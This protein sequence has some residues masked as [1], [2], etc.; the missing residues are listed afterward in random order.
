MAPESPTDLADAKLALVRE[1]LRTR[2]RWRRTVYSLPGRAIR[3]KLLETIYERLTL[4]RSALSEW[5][6]SPPGAAAGEVCQAL[7]LI[8]TPIDERDAWQIADALS[9]VLPRVLPA[10]SLAGALWV[11]RSRTPGRGAHWRDVFECDELD[12]L[13]ADYDPGARRFATEGV[14]SLV[15]E[16][17][18]Q[19]RLVRNDEGRHSR[20]RERT[21]GY[22]LRYLALV[23]F[24]FVG[25][26]ASTPRL[27]SGADASWLPSLE[28]MLLVA[29]AGGLGST[30]SGALRVRTLERITELQAMWG[31]LLAQIAIGAA[32]AVVVV[33]VLET[34]LVSIGGADSTAKWLAIGFASGFS[35]PFALGI[36]E[37][38]ASPGNAAPAARDGTEG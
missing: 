9:A 18:Q 23:L 27:V 2:P 16:R 33:L 37:R 38:V 19:L 6:T 11:E 3:R 30:L 1:Q 22:H 36:L 7:A 25:A 8:E 14:E 12:L 5:Q 24:V 29:L 17:L 28:T 15:R 10:A 21:R 20:A 34:G 32:L 13:L 35:E 31:G 26:L 4:L